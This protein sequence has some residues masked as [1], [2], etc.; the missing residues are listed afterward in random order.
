VLRLITMDETRG[1]FHR[2]IVQSGAARRGLS[3]IEATSRARRLMQLLDIDPDAGE[4]L[5]SAPVER[6][7]PLQMQIARENARFAEPDPAFPP[8]FDDFDST[9]TFADRVAQA[10]AERGV[11]FIIGT[12]REEMHAFLV[13]DPS[14]AAPDPA[15][16]AGHFAAL[17][18]DIEAYR[19]RRP[20]GDLRDLLADLVTDHRFLFPVL[21]VA[22][23]IAR[24]GRNSFV[25]QFDWA[26]AGSVWRACHC[27]ELPFV[28]GTRGAWD[29]P[30]LAGMD[31]GEYAGIS[32]SM[33]A[34]WTSFAR[35]G[36]PMV[37]GL[38]WPGYE[39]GQRW[40][41]RFGGITGVVGDLAGVAVRC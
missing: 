13:A 14:M 20:G 5:R 2:A 6:L 33:M 30:M 35:G 11:D 7:I 41:M 17:G 9:E 22:E 23:R 26:P 39:N 40:T 10:A 36:A 18:G 21:G 31:D 32:E 12:T 24:A 34:A 37:P 25:Y 4:R 15:A 29:A 1:L 19:R 28:F 16:V 38:A 8:V 27:I 3:S